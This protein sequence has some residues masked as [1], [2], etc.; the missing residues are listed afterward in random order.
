MPDTITEPTKAE[1]L[2]IETTHL[3]LEQRARDVEPRYAGGFESLRKAAPHLSAYIDRAE[4]WARDFE[5]WNH[6]QRGLYISGPTGC[7]KTGIA[8]GIRSVLMAER[9][10]DVRFEN[11][12][13]FI[14]SLKASFDRD[15]GMESEAKMIDRC[16]NAPLLIIDDLGAGRVTG[17]ELDVLGRLINLRYNA[18]KAVVITSN[19]RGSELT[20]DGGPWGDDPNGQRIVSRLRE[21]VDGMKLP[22]D[23]P[24][25]RAKGKAPAA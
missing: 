9:H 1:L 12:P 25:M 8:Y 17:Y 16:A 4:Q 10:F 20:G 19:L 21:M 6:E 22:G 7:G 23:L 3:W 18:C 14:A 24:D 5:P 2:S 11:W 13:E 15:A